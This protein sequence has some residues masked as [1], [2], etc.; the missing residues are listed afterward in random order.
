MSPREE[1]P[2]GRR[3]P[4]SA[5]AVQAGICNHPRKAWHRTLARAIEV[6]LNGEHAH[7][8]VKCELGPAPP[9]EGRGRRALHHHALMNRL[10]LAT[11]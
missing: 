1:T 10:A 5:R 2:L 8:R 7:Q 3:N 4:S 9:F 6:R 11:P